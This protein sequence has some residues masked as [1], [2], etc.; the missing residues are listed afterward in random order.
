MKTPIARLLDRKAEVYSE[1]DA[2]DKEES[3]EKTIVRGEVF[4][5]EEWLEAEREF[6][7]SQRLN[8]VKTV[9][10]RGEFVGLEH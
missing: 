2:M 10:P 4:D 1:L 5:H 8:L 6:I 7:N 9:N 3:A